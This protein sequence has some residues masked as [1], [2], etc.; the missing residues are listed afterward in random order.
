MCLV[1][2]IKL[3]NYNS[4]SAEV[5][6]KQGKK[7]K[8]HECWRECKAAE[9]GGMISVW[10]RYKDKKGHV[11]LLIFGTL[12]EIV[13]SASPGLLVNFL[14]GT[15]HT[16]I[17]PLLEEELHQ[18]FVRFSFIPE[19]LTSQGPIGKC[20]KENPFVLFSQFCS[21]LCS[22]C[23][24]RNWSDRFLFFRAS[25]TISWYQSCS[26][27]SLCTKCSS[28]L[29]SFLSLYLKLLYSHSCNTEM[30]KFLYIPR[31]FHFLIFFLTVTSLCLAVLR[32]SVCC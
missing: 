9:M 10:R 14:H 6:Y 7:W 24:R 19:K 3:H 20:K 29:S 11:L 15:W 18:Y 22:Q 26:H 4:R 23:S 17:V 1:S 13:I 27:A 25:Q 8:K 2:I 28:S 30:L 31:R 32:Q 5:V 16:H 21:R 12:W